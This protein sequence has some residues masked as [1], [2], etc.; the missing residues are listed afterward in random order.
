MNQPEERR[1]PC[2]WC[3]GPV[4]DGAR[5]DS[6]F[7]SKLCRQASW[8]FD[9]PGR[10]RRVAADVGRDASV[11]D[12][13][14]ASRAAASGPA[15]RFAYA[16]PPYPGDA[17]YYRD[18]PDYAGEV[19]HAQLVDRL[20]A[21]Y[22]DGWALSTSSRAL[23]DVLALCPPAVRVGAWT[24][25]APPTDSARA[26]RAW[27][28]VI[29]AGG[30]PLPRGGVT[31]LDWVHAATPRAFPGQIV[32]TKPAGFSW[33]LF[34]NLGARPDLG[35]TLDDLFPGSGAVT[36]AW[37]RYVAPASSARRVAARS[38][39]DGILDPSRGFDVPLWGDDEPETAALSAP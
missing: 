14:D 6:R 38:R 27:E 20:I 24:K 8:R 4:P 31:V 28:P 22:P 25:P 1:P 7:C 33:W 32:G 29:F 36:V 16:D 2:E 19:D 3:S 17:H 34:D 18:H 10:E 35:D 9:R 15:R 23:R 39:R 30:R 12:L 37:A 13:R 26:R 5:R 21:D 11:R